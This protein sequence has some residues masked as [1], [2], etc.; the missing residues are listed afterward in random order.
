ME[1]GDDGALGDTDPGV[2]DAVQLRLN[3]TR[4]LHELPGLPGLLGSA[5]CSS[6]MRMSFRLLRRITRDPLGVAIGEEAPSLFHPLRI[7][8]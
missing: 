8:I 2:G 4:E 7:I 3:P 5:F 1:R 6:R